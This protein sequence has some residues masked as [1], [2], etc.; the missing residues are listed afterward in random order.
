M[1]GSGSSAGVFFVTCYPPFSVSFIGLHR[2]SVIF[3]SYTDSFKKVFP[4]R[5]TLGALMRLYKMY[6]ILLFILLTIE[7]CFTT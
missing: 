2:S 4:A 6:L 5:D 1:K 7:A 3:T